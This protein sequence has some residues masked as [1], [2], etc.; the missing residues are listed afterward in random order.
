[1][2]PILYL[3]PRL[4]F[5]LLRRNGRGKGLDETSWSGVLDP[6][7]IIHDVH[8]NSWGLWRK[9]GCSKNSNMYLWQVALKP[10]AVR[11]G[12]SVQR[13]QVHGAVGKAAR[14]TGRENASCCLFLA[15]FRETGLYT[16]PV[17]M[18]RTASRTI[19]LCHRFCLK[20]VVSRILALLLGPGRVISVL[21]CCNCELLLKPS[22]AADLSN[23]KYYL[24]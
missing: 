20:A 14:A 1:M 8:I 4:N 2:L 3:S 13:A 15:I 5:A 11:G 24:L 10:A 9:T 19:W 6:L 23:L 12:E 21:W 17:K 18:G 7:R 22:F 16:V